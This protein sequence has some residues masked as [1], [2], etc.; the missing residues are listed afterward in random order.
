MTDS[1]VTINCEQAYNL[2]DRKRTMLE[3]EKD[4][5]LKQLTKEMLTKYNTPYSFL[6][7]FISI[8]R[9][10]VHDGNL[11]EHTSYEDKMEQFFLE[12]SYDRKLGRANDIAVAAAHNRGIMGESA[13]MHLTISDFLFIN[14]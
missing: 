6:W 5:K 9:P 8:R 13:V 1:L 3:I 10:F 7:G 12:A 4:I 11:H 14:S 2:A